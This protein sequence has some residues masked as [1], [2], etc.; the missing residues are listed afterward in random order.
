MA[1]D[2]AFAMV[3]LGV[4]GSRAPG[5]LRLFLLS[6]AIVDDI[7]AVLVIAVFYS[8]GV[9]PVWL[10]GALGVIVAIVIGR[11]L[12]IGHPIFY[13]VPALALWVCVHQSGVHATIAGVVLGLLTPVGVAGR[14]LVGYRLEQL[15]H[16]W[17][18]L[19]VIPLFALANSG[20]SID[21]SASAAC[22]VEPDHLGCHRRVRR[23]QA[24]GYRGRDDSGSPLRR[25]T[26]PRG[27]VPAPGARRGDPRRHGLHGV[28]LRRGAR[29]SGTSAE[30]G[31]DR[32]RRGIDPEWRA[33][34]RLAVV[35]SIGAG[36]L[37]FGLT[38]P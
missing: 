13:F 21:S 18:S 12:G 4:L 29:A 14:G 27:P 1:T 23:G 16:P 5:P 37:G 26:P 17:S 36:F 34:R 25:R 6:L 38:C 32:D 20:V 3:V 33:W 24:A 35:R 31:E 30:R 9:S 10:A 19:L 2:I 11:R 7:G 8:H 15:L 28:A 22:L